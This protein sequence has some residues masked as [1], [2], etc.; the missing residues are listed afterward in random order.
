MKKIALISLFAGL[1]LSFSSCSETPC[2]ANGVWTWTNPY[3]PFCPGT[4]LNFNEDG[5]CVMIV[6]DCYSVCPTGADRGLVYNISWTLIESSNTLTL[7]FNN[8]GEVCGA[9][10]THTDPPDPI[11]GTFSCGDDAA[12]LVTGTYTYTL[13]R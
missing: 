12:T 3:L 10:T 5:T 1:I 9:P 8:Q 13:T 2:I 7:V 6:P 11:A 4:T